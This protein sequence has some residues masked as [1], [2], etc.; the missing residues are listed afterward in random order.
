MGADSS[1]YRYDEPPVQS[2][3]SLETG[4]PDQVDTINALFKTSSTV[5]RQVYIGNVAKQKPQCTHDSII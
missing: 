4:Y 5:G 1:I 2:T 3:Y